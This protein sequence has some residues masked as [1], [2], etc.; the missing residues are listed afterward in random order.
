MLQ[1]ERAQDKRWPLGVLGDSDSHSFQDRVTFPEGSGVRGDAYAAVTWQWVD[2]LQRLRGHE[3]DQGPWGA[4][5]SHSVRWARLQDTLGLWNRRIR[6][7]DFLYNLARSGAVCADLQHGPLQ[8]VKPLL[9]QMDR[10]PERWARGLVVLRIGIND[11]GTEAF[12]QR[13]VQQDASALR[14]IEACVAHID[15]AVRTLRK[16]HPDTRLVLVGIFNN[17][18]WVN[19]LSKWHD[20]VALGRIDA[21]MDLFDAG[22]RGIATRVGRAAFFDDRAWFASRWGGRDAMGAPAYQSL[23]LRPGLVVSNTKGDTWNHC[24]LADGHNGSVWNALWAQSLVALAHRDL[25]MPVSPIRPD[26]VS[27][28]FASGAGGVPPAP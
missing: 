7:E 12:L 16:A 14:D 28:L 8:Q 22:L 27:S 17:A 18:H 20:P 25:Q 19:L 4:W 9:V 3:I 1:H 10:E 6:K 24:S 23:A 21:G 2:S 15:A 11:I 13:L 5:G 26:E